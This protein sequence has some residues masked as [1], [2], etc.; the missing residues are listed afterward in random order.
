MAGYASAGGAYQTEAGY[1]TAGGVYITEAG[2]AT[3]GGIY[4]TDPGYATFGGV[5]ITSAGYATAG[6]VY[7]TGCFPKSELVHTTPDMYVP[8]GSLK[9]GDKIY[10]WDAIREKAQHTVITEVHKYT[11]SQIMYFNNSIKVSSTH[12]LMVLENCVSGELIPKWKVAFDV[13]VGD[14]VIGADGKL[15]TIMTKSKHWYDEGIEVLN[16]STDSGIPFLAGNCVA[17]AENARDAIEWSNSY[18]TQKLF[19]E[20]A[21]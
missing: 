4:W 3:A 20:T 17:R 21:A 19:R 16:L 8:I 15:I 7:L 1:A 14:C 6:G 10:S 9:A 11:V 5:Y 13:S 2:Y 18:V 12:P